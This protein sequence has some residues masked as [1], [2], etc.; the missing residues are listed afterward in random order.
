MILV[1]NFLKKFSIKEERECSLKRREKLQV[2]LP[3][4]TGMY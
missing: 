3:I 2:T 4:P 1:E